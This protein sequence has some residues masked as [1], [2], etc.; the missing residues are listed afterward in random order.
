MGK[1][2]DQHLVYTV[3][4]YMANEIPYPSLEKPFFQSKAS[5][6]HWSWRRHRINITTGFVLF[7]VSINLMQRVCMHNPAFLCT[8]CSL[9]FQCIWPLNFIKFCH[10]IFRNCNSFSWQ[11]VCFSH[12]FLQHTIETYITL[13]QYKSVAPICGTQHR[14][15]KVTI[16]KFWIM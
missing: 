12:C 3:G 10:L 13:L 6:S 9:H 1:L 2:D 15:W 5:M 7:Q 16:W 4:H 11:W 8:Y 14:W